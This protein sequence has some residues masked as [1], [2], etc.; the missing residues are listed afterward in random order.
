VSSLQSPFCCVLPSILSETGKRIEKN[1]NKDRKVLGESMEMGCLKTGR[2]IRN[3]K[4]RENENN[5][6]LF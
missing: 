2:E 3:K 4:G 5:K 6:V 1:V